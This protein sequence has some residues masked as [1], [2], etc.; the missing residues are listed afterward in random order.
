MKIKNKKVLLG[1][2]G[3]VDSSVAALFLKNKGYEVIG[4]FMKNFSDSKNKITGECSYVEDKRSAVKICS[5][6][7]IAL[8]IDDKER[9]YKK[10]VIDKVFS[11]YSR[12]LTP[13]PDADCNKEIKFPSLIKKADEIGAY[14]VATGHY[15]RIVEGKEEFEL[16]RA[17]DESKDQSYFLW[18]LKENQ[19]KRILF[20]IWDLEKEEVRSIASKNKF[21]NWDRR[22]SRGICFVGKVNLKDFLSGKIKEKK[23]KVVNSK[24]E[25]IGFHSGS[26]YLTIGQRIG[27]KI[28]VEIFK[29]FNSEKMYVAEKRT[30]SVIVAVGKDSPLL[31]KRRIKLVKINFINKNFKLPDCGL[32]CRIRHLGELYSGHLVKIKGRLYFISKKSIEAVAE[33]QSIVVYEGKRVVCGAEIRY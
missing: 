14:Y 26:N 18:G 2:S 12:N 25:L 28:G 20:P 9:E 4:Y 23:G 30:G 32:K 31:R 16:H 19:L 24:G 3:G 27:E 8:I 5:L 17:K 22:S 7:K 33:G 29:E 6:L 10:K 1:M 15:A 11:Y 21:P 13:N